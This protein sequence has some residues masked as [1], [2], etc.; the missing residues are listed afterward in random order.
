VTT[1]IRLAVLNTRPRAQAAQLSWLLERAG[2]EAVEA[3]SIEVVSA[4]DPVELESARRDL[5]GGSFAWVVLPSQNAGGLLADR[6]G[7]AQV[8][9]GSQTA[10]ALGLQPAHSLDHFSAR[11]ALQLLR[12]LIQPGQHIL[13]PHAAEGRDELIDGLEASGVVVHAPVAYRTVAV[14]PSALAAVA[15]RLRR[16]AIQAVTVCSPSAVHA[17]LA[18]FDRA[19][20][21]RVPLVCLGETTADAIRQ[22]GLT[23]A[24]IA[25]QTTMASLVAAVAASL[26]VPA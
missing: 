21:A 19:D 4:W 8:V 12:P 11:A 14:D 3:P 13:V 9:C 23:V 5:A 10:R 20:L 22:A 18:A 25:R 7:Q 6:L 26:E 15:A 16:G 1:S 2:F 24:G 17:L